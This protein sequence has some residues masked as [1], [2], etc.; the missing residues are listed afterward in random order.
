MGMWPAD[1]LR[2]EDSQFP[3]T[4]SSHLLPMWQPGATT[5]G[6]P[7]SV[8]TGG[9]HTVGGEALLLRSLRPPTLCLAV[10]MA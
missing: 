3:S 10:V 8:A 2:V 7:L 1:A 5:G 6:A 9:F 4:V